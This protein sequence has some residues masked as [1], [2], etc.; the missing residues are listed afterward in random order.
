M[1]ALASLAVIF[2]GL[3]SVAVAATPPFPL[4]PAWVSREMQPPIPAFRGSVLR[5]D[6]SRVPAY[7]DRIRL[8]IYHRQGLADP[9]SY[10]FAPQ[11]VVANGRVYVGSSSDE[12]LFCLDAATGK[13]LWTLR[14]EGPIR[15]A[16]I[17]DAGAV[18]VCSDDGSV[19]CADAATGAQRWQ[20]RIAP[21][22]GFALNNT[23]LMSAWPVRGGLTLAGGRLYCAAGVFPEQG[24]FLAALDPIT[25]APAWVREIPNV[26]NGSLF[27]DGDTLWTPTHRT[28]PCQFDLSTG[29]P[30]L[31]PLPILL[32]R[33]AAQIWRLD[34]L[35]AWGPDE[36]EIIYLQL[37]PDSKSL[38]ARTKRSGSLPLGVVSPLHG[39]C[40]VAG[41]THFVLVQDDRVLAVEIP[42]FRQAVADRLAAANAGA[43]PPAEL[44]S[45]GKLMGSIAA[46]D[47]HLG[48]RLEKHAA[49]I[50]PI[51]GEESYR[52]AILAGDSLILGGLRTVRVLDLRTGEPRWGGAVDSQV[53]TLAAADDS[54]YAGTDSGAVYCFRSGAGQPQE[55]A[56]PHVPA[57]PAFDEVAA[58]AVARAG[59]DKGICVVAGGGTGKLAAAIAQ[60][61]QFH[62]VVLEPD[63]ARAGAQRRY[64]DATGLYG[65][66]VV[67]RQESGNNLTGYPFGLANLMI[68]EDAAVPY[69][70]GTLLPLLQPYGGVIVLQT[71]D[72]PAWRGAEL[73]PW[74]PVT[75]EWLAAARGALP[76]GG[77]WPTA[78]GSPGNS[79]NTGEGRVPAAGGALR[80]QWFGEPY[81]TDSIDR[82][83]VPM[84]PLF[85]NGIAV[86]LRRGDMVLTQDAYNGTILW[87]REVPGIERVL[88]SHNSS[89]L[90]FSADG[91]WV[92]ALAG[93]ECLQLDALTGE[94]K[95]TLTSVAAGT[96]WGYIGPH[97]GM[98]IGTS[99]GTP[100]FTSTGGRQVS[101][102]KDWSAS[103]PAVS[104][105]LF[106]IE[107]A[108]GKK[109]WTFSEGRI[110]NPTIAV[111]R[112]RIFLAHSR[113]AAALANPAGSMK[114]GD[115][116]A[117]DAAGGAEIVALD[118]TSG[119]PLWR[120]P[121][122]R[123]LD[124][125]SHWIMYLT[126]TDDFL[127][128]TH[129]FFK[130][131]GQTSRR[132]Y[133]F[134]LFDAATGESRWTQWLPAESTGRHAGLSYGKNSLSSRPIILGNRFYLRSN[135]GNQATH[136][137]VYGF[138][139][140]S[141][142]PLGKGVETGTHDAGCSVAL[143]SLNALYYRDYQHAVYDITTGARYRLSGATRP[144]C[145][146]S[147]MPVGGIVFAPEGGAGCSCGLSYQVSFA[148]APDP[149]AAPAPSQSRK[150]TR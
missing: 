67:V 103:A 6:E 63:A 143:G 139:L 102:L 34:R 69:P 38:G 136:G 52:A 10:D 124:A 71:P 62:V 107:I 17:V 119:R 134:E 50:A 54:L 33:G 16:P 91:N 7:A 8:S 32:G 104:R 97:D 114:M 90:T 30:R 37:S 13:R 46:S 25:G 140:H 26:V 40:A 116:I 123:N 76:G 138:D 35:V 106:A 101:A 48:D 28:T 147:T 53:W 79:M 122:T 132:G 146:P 135:L 117:Q 92:F 42:K 20:Q 58:L 51:R 36:G 11:P 82:H 145:W 29:K 44:A 49:W 99:Q 150:G 131:D 109:R 80:L 39:W 47:K 137:L 110:L 149:A 59:R 133:D 100:D 98:L 64:L 78:N 86:M 88:A 75:G 125:E 127:L 120:H 12:A 70:P 43:E 19:Y 55:I 126:A 85:E 113:N 93:A 87:R 128:A 45:Y 81:A 83:A 9:A 41:P 3:A 60:R 72:E 56:T 1:K 73:S 118:A 130:P 22:T 111:G 4:A 84:T 121:I 66:R 108:T 142:Q 74:E 61:S 95:A 115:W 68:S 31:D 141:G 105:D 24:V 65:H 96:D 2:V 112:D 144:A 27:V 23:R 94:H 148:L 129:T 21:R 77:Q 57:D 14:V 5:K 15:F 89:P 18:Y